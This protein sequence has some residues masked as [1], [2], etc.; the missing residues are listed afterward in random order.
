MDAVFKPLTV[1]DMLF[2]VEGCEMALEAPLRVL[3]EEITETRGETMQR[4]M[5]SR[6]KGLLEVEPGSQRVYDAKIG[7]LHRTV[8]DF[9][10]TD[11]GSAS[12]RSEPLEDQSHLLLAASYLRQ[13]KMTTRR[14]HEN[15]WNDFWHPAEYS[16]AHLRKYRNTKD[17]MSIRIIDDID[18]VGQDFWGPARSGLEDDNSWLKEALDWHYY[19]G[20]CNPTHRQRIRH[21]TESLTKYLNWTATISLADMSD[22]GPATV[23]G[24]LRYNRDSFIK[25]VIAADLGFWVEAK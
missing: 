1:R 25:L 15:S 17:P 22:L 11:K 13:L 18:Q 3:S 10:E 2:A 6:T 12:I 20:D 19:S 7:Y 9:F 5:I 24:N 4:R 21:M 16:M 8:K 14:H 23:K